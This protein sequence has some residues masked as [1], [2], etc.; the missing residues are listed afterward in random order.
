MSCFVPLITLTYL[1]CLDLWVGILD[2]ED[3][4][5]VYIYYVPVGVYKRVPTAPHLRSSVY[6][7]DRRDT[8]G[9]R[10]KTAALLLQHARHRAAVNRRVYNA[11]MCI[12]EEQFVLLIMTLAIHESGL[13][14]QKVHRFAGVWMTVT[15]TLKKKVTMG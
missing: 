5:N 12:N 15:M 3:I 4:Q 11:D 6:G 8:A 10:V 14:K 2:S 9:G 7:C 13:T 1:M